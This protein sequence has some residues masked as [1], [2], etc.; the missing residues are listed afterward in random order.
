MRGRALQ[1]ADGSDIDALADNRIAI[2]PLRLDTTD[3]PF[4]TRSAGLFGQ[5]PEQE[6]Q[7]KAGSGLCSI[8]GGRMSATASQTIPSSFRGRNTRI[9]ATRRPS[10]GSASGA[11]NPEAYIV[12]MI[13]M[14]S[15]TGAQRNARAL[16]DLI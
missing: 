11:R 12:Q 15:L 2:T 7:E 9:G 1:P 16:G 4:M 3:D 10:M 6:R 14:R 5:A 13:Y 8:L